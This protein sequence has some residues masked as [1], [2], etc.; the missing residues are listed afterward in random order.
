M[1]SFSL[2]L[3]HTHTDTHTSTLTHLLNPLSVA[4]MYVLIA[5][6]IALGNLS[7]LIPGED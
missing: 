6:H 7:G 4:H 2:L 3:L 1:T 5:D